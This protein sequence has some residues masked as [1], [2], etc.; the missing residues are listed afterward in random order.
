MFSL[1][2]NI[3]D[4]CFFTFS[5]ILGVQL[6]ALIQQYNQRLA[7]HLSEAKL[8]LSQFQS[9]ANQHYQGDLL[10]MVVKYQKNTEAS[11]VSTGDLIQQLIAR[12]DHLQQQTALL[13]DFNYL[14]QV[15]NFILYSDKQIVLATLNDFSLS[16]PLEVNALCTGAFIAIF[17]L[18]IKELGVFLMKRL[19]QKLWPEHNS[20]S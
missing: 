19:G 4:R 17:G 10:E 5:F 20:L 8:Q 3:I 12:I 14:K 16:I 15:S 6:P 13:L 9:I 11:I 2:N 1:F 18:L 7:G